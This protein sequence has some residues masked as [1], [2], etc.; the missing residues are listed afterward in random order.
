M[1]SVGSAR[2]RTPDVLIDN[3]QVIRAKASRLPLMTQV[4]FIQMIKSFYNLMTGAKNEE[5][6]FKAFNNLSSELLK[7][8]SSA[9]SMFPR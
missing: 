2:E 5:D 3:G 7:L 8:G 9:R 1:D 4:E 6:L